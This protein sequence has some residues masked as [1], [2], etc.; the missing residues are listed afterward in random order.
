MEYIQ[1][2]M[3]VSSILFLRAPCRL[4]RFCPSR[5]NPFSTSTTDTFRVAERIPVHAVVFMVLNVHFWDAVDN[6]F[7]NR[8]EMW[9]PLFEP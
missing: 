3:S 4:I 5:L 8:S 2:V 6:P 9:E 7:G 1:A